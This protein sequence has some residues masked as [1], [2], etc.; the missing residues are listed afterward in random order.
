LGE[1][2]APITLEVTVPEA[3]AAESAQFDLGVLELD[4]KRP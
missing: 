3:A 1:P 2:F 4:S